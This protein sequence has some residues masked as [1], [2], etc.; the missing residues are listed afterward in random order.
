MW[1]GIKKYFKAEKRIELEDKE[2]VRD[3]INGF[4]II[5]NALLIA[6]DENI[7]TIDEEFVRICK[8]YMGYSV[9]LFFYQWLMKAYYNI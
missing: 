5:V 4:C 6:R 9:S 7:V 1:N 3:T 8:L 2:F